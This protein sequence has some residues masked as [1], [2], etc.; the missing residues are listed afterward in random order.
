MLDEAGFPNAI[1]VA[2][3]DLDADTIWHLKA[4]GARI[5]LWGVGTSLITSRSCPALG[6]VYK[7]AAEEVNGEL[8]PKIKISENP[9]KM[10]NPGYK[11]IIRLYE[12]STGKAIA[13]LIT[14]NDEVIDDTQPLEIFHPIE[15]WKRMILTDFHCKELLQPVFVDGEKVYKQKSIQEIV[16][17]EKQDFA[18]FWDEYTRVIM[19]SEFKVDLSQKLYDMKNDL[20]KNYTMTK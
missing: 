9:A 4:Q 3:N 2:S 7:L 10:T 1:I 6:G 5:D 15:T 20:L 18:T 11:K 14:L 12:N 13:D 8:V 16:E 19:P 17:H